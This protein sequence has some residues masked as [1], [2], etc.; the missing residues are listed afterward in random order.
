[1]LKETAL[2]SDSIRDIKQQMCCQHSNIM[3]RG[4]G[5]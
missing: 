5:D 1:M 3:R 4:G 2:Y